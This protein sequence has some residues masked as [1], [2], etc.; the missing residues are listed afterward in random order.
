MLPI[1]ASCG[2][3]D[4]NNLT[5]AEVSTFDKYKIRSWLKGAWSSKHKRNALFIPETSQRI[6]ISF[7]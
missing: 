4:Q 7:V 6:F 5:R 3:A 2:H 1:L